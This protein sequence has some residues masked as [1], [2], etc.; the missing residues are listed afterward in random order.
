MS[1]GMMLPSYVERD[2]RISLACDADESGLDFLFMGES[3]SSNVFI[4]LAIVADSTE[5][6]HL[7]TGIVNVFSRTPTT[8]AL[9]IAELDS[10]ANGRLMLG[11]GTSTKPLIEG[12]HGVQFTRP[13]SRL[14]EYITVIRKAWTGDRFEYAGEFHSPTGGRILELPVHDVPIAIAALGENNRRLT[15]ELADIWIPHLIPRSAFADAAQPVRDSARDS[16]RNPD[17]ISL[18]PYIPTCIA[19]RET[20]T[21]ALAKHIAS[22]VGP[23]EVYRNAVAAAGYEAI[24]DEIH[25]A[26]VDGGRDGAADVVPTDLIDD[27]GIAGPPDLAHDRIEEWYAAGADSI[28]IHFPPGTDRGDIAHTMTALG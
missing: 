9:S 15:G 26:W 13:V 5:S 8:I 7:G 14:R 10:I 18:R 3:A 25:D 19:D 11:L 2:A 17:D 23:A 27:I 1:I 6:I 20:A 22:Y 21:T 24:T 16:G 28:V 4:D 12:L